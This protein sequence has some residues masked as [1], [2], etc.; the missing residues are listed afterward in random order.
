[1]KINLLY[2]ASLKETLNCDQEILE[3]D[4]DIDTIQDLKTFLV[5]RGGVWKS[6]FLANNALLASVNHQMANEQTSIHDQDEVAFFP[7]VTG[8]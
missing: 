6:S 7:P 5:K 2:F 8:G 1:M 4:K 3:L